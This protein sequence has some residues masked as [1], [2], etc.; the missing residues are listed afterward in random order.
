M[1]AGPEDIK[2]DDRSISPN[3]H[4]FVINNRSQGVLTGVKDVQSFDADMIC[5]DTVQGILTIKG[6]GLHVSRLTLEKG[7][8]DIDGRIDSIEY[9][10]DA[11]IGKHAGRVLGRLFR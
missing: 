1:A 7:E 8:V 6:E 2:L 9:S 3:P 5:L 4:R 11:D 10:E